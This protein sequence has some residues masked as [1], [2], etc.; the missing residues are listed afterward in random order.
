MARVRATSAPFES[1]EVIWSDALYPW[2][3]TFTEVSRQE[4]VDLTAL[5]P[6]SDLEA[7][8]R[9]AVR[10]GW[11]AAVDPVLDLNDLLLGIAVEWDATPGKKVDRLHPAYVLATGDLPP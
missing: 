4:D 7:M 1:N 10:A 3:F 5:F 8:R 9:A 11:L 6:E 2:R